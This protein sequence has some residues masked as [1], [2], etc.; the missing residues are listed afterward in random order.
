MV[1]EK[2]LAEIDATLGQLIMNAESMLE[3]SF[4]EISCYEVEAMQKTQASLLAHLLHLDGEYAIQRKQQ[5]ASEKIS[6]KTVIQKKL[7]KF[8]KLNTHFI[9]RIAKKWG[10]VQ[11]EKRPARKKMRDKI[12]AKKY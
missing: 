7:Q 9:E 5:K 11:F 8:Q 2:L 6:E 1:G 10:K 3:A 4:I 12:S